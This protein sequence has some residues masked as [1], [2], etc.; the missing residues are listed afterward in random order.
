M[1]KRADDKALFTVVGQCPLCSGTLVLRRRQR[2]QNPFLGCTNYPQCRFIADYDE[3]MAAV[4]MKASQD[5]M[6]ASLAEK[7][8]D[9]EEQLRQQRRQRAR[10]DAVERELRNL[11][12]MNRMLE[13]QR[14]RLMN[15]NRSTWFPTSGEGSVTSHDIR[16]LL[17]WA[18][19]DRQPTGQIS[20]HDVC[21]RLT[22]LLDRLK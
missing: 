10:L 15:H 7:V 13:E 3:A 11:R 14:D 5:A 21:V 4:G 22:E 18:H 20:A 16:D 9:L 6:V 19:P 12:V 1:K 17:R 8:T 2:D